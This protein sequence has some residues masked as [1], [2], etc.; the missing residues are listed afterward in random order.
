MRHVNYVNFG[1][2]LSTVVAFFSP[3]FLKPDIDDSNAPLPSP[4]GGGGG[5][6]EPGGGGGAPQGGGGGGGAPGATGGGGGGGTPDEGGAGGGGGGAEPEINN[7]RVSYNYIPESNP[8][9][10]L[11][12]PYTKT[13]KK[14]L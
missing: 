7:V 3:P 11:G 13:N 12:K 9:Y 5:G 6:A 2:L 14:P 10:D 1:P 4:E 8:L